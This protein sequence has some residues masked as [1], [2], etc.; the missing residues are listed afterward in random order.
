MEKD[1]S[2]LITFK[3]LSYCTATYKSPL[4]QPATSIRMYG[5]YDYAIEI[6]NTSKRVTYMYLE[7]NYA[8]REL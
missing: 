7:I 4:N 1:V 2:A 5:R 6:Y 3:I 8:W